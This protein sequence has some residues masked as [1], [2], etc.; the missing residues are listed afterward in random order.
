MPNPRRGLYFSQPPDRTIEELLARFDI[1][2]KIEVFPAGGQL[3]VPPLALHLRRGGHKNMA[4]LPPHFQT[5]HNSKN[6]SKNL[7]L[8]VQI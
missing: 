4:T 7:T 1:P 2:A 6:T 8:A 3:S 5:P